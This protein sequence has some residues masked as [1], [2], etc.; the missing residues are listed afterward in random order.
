MKNEYGLPRS[1]INFS[2][3]RSSDLQKK[4]NH[5]AKK[6]TFIQDRISHLEMR[7]PSDK[8]IALTLLILVMIVAILYAVLM[9]WLPVTFICC[10][11]NGCYPHSTRPQAKPLATNIHSDDNTVLANFDGYLILVKHSKDKPIVKFMPLELKSVSVE[12]M[13]E[14]T[15]SLN[16][17]TD[18]ATIGLLHEKHS[19]SFFVRNIDVL[20]AES[21]EFKIYKCSVN[22]ENPLVV[23]S[24]FHCVIPKEFSSICVKDKLRNKFQSMSHILTIHRLEY[25]IMGDPTEIVQGKFSKPLQSGPE[26]PTTI[27]S[28]VN[29]N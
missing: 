11:I 22:L 17:E 27:G 15:F 2:R 3:S 4:S 25:E 28:D 18:C 5:Q 7:F 8:T 1:Q 14:G 10:R 21:L 20:P 9:G 23:S 6:S 13:S 12:H 26:S 19:Y 16:L 29:L 24:E